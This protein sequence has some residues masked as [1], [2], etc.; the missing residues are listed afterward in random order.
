M[1]YSWLLEDLKPQ[2]EG[3]VVKVKSCILKV[4]L[5]SANKV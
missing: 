4:Y 1:R 3:G 5:N 2:M